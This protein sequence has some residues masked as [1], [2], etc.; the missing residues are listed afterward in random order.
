MLDFIFKL[1][2]II[3]DK[4]TFIIK[5]FVVTVCIVVVVFSIIV[6]SFWDKLVEPKI[7]NWL[8]TK[9]DAYFKAAMIDSRTNVAINHMKQLEN[10]MNIELMSI[11]N[12]LYGDIDAVYT[13]SYSFNKEDIEALGSKKGPNY[14]QYIFANLQKHK[15]IVILNRRYNSFS[16][17]FCVNSQHKSCRTKNNDMNEDITELLKRYPLKAEAGGAESEES[18]YPDHIHLIDISPIRPNWDASTT[19][20]I[21]GYI[22]VHRHLPSE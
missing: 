19:S 9:L 13:I 14:R 20:S 11:K 10:K 8:S 6:Y 18:A 5:Y 1:I 22:L 17:K 4:Y 16:L 12:T 15:V 3:L 2:N 7:D 21:D